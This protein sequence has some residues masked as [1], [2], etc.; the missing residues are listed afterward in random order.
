MTGCEGLVCGS[1]TLVIFRLAQSVAF[2]G[3][4]LSVFQYHDEHSVEAHLYFDQQLKYHLKN[5]FQSKKKLELSWHR[6]ALKTLIRW[7]RWSQCRHLTWSCQNISSNRHWATSVQMFWKYFATYLCLLVLCSFIQ[8]SSKWQIF[9]FFF[10][11]MSLHHCGR[12]RRSEEES[13]WNMMAFHCCY[14]TNMTLMFASCKFQEHCLL[15]SPNILCC[16]CLPL[17]L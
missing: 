2:D 6:N 13:S 12:S 11:Q 3:W 8:I 17:P 10:S 15:F 16:C 4:K 1:H 5:I 14:P 9:F 7:M